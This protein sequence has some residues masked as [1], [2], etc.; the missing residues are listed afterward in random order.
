MSNTRFEAYKVQQQLN[1]SGKVYD[2]Y[3]PER[4]EFGEP[5]KDAELVASLKA[6]YH[7]ETGFIRV[8]MTD[9]TNVRKAR[10]SGEVKQPMLLCLWESVVEADLK[11]GDYTMIN[12]KKYSVTA[13]TNVQEW[14]I[15][16]DISLEVEDD[17]NNISI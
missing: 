7:E 8:G 9:T 10:R 15:I 2:F 1:R 4:N 12:G 14:N 11:F 13:V 17:G 3:R 16:A 6:L 5:T